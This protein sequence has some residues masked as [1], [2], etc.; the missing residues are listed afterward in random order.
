MEEVSLA[1]AEYPELLAPTVDIAVV[2]TDLIVL[3]RLLV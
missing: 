2:V 1:S 3:L